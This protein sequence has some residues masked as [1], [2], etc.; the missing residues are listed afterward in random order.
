MTRLLPEHPKGSSGAAVKQLLGILRVSYGLLPGCLQ[1]LLDRAPGS[2][3]TS[4]GGQA[5]LIWQQ[6][7]CPCVVIPLFHGLPRSADSVIRCFDFQ[8]P[9]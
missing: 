8:L 3:N 6:L 5:L 1:L 7:L 9:K 4:L 2:W